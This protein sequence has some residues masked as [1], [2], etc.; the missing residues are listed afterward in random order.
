[1]AKFPP[2]PFITSISDVPNDEGG[3]VLLTW[4]ASSLDKNAATL[5]YYTIWREISQTA[6]GVK[7]AQKVEKASSYS[8]R[9]ANRTMMVNGK[10]SSWEWIAVV[11]SRQAPTYSYVAP[12]SSDSMSTTNGLQSFLVVAQTNNPYEFYPSNVDRGYSVDNLAPQAPRNLAFSIRPDTLVLHWNPNPETDIGRYVI[13]RSAHPIT[14]PITLLPYASSRDTIFADTM[15]LHRAYYVIRAQD[16]HEN[17]SLPGNQVRVIFPGPLPPQWVEAYLDSVGVLCF[18]A[19]DSNLFAGTGE[20]IFRS[21]DGDTSWIVINE[22]LTGRVVRA[23]VAYG[24]NVL[25]ATD[26]GV[27]VSSNDGDRWTRTSLTNSNVNGFALSPDGANLFASTIGSGVFLTTNNGTSWTQV[28][29][30]LTDTNVTSLAVL[31]TNLIAGTYGYGGGV[32]LSTNNGTSWIR[33]D[34]AVAAFIISLSVSGTN[35]FAIS[36]GP[37]PCVYRCQSVFISTDNGTSWTVAGVGGP[38]NPRTLAV[39]G[40]NLF[41]GTTGGVLV[42]T[43]SGTNWTEVST[44]LA[45]EVTTALYVYGSFI[46]AGTTGGVWKRPLSEMITS[47]HPPSSVLPRELRLE[48]NYPNPFNPLTTITYSLPSSG[49]V[50]LSV[51]NVLGQEIATLVDGV[52]YAGYKSVSF[53]ANRLSSGIYI[54]R[55]TA[56]TFTDVKKMVL[57]K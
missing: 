27:F 55:I 28:N 4:S 22:G 2:H 51:F 17:Y 1:M 11:P 53:D 25:A 43:N 50:Y 47:V 14:N 34:T 48:Q 52:E 45:G 29:T 36:P 24:K 21:S 18:A 16:T 54:Y 6:K 12:T 41:A 46:F 32:Y 38:V 19:S 26:S 56:G 23:M 33:V 44:G 5:P 3:N 57:I 37:F 15:P 31:G 42:T 13:Y 10:E 7:A 9:P 8:Q 40:T 20:G 49:R 39:S 35:L 30:G